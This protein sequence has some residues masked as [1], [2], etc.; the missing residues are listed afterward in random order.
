MINVTKEFKI[1]MS[2]RLENY[3][4]LCNNVHGHTYRLLVTFARNNE[5]VN[6]TDKHKKGM[7]EDFSIIKKLVN[8]LIVDKMDHA[9]VFNTHD[10]DSLDIAQFMSSKINQKLCGL[11]FRTTAENMAEWM[12]KTLNSNLKNSKSDIK[13]TKIVLFET[14]S[15][16]AKYKGE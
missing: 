13:C 7:V 3:D 14:A 4:G 16:F 10:Q 15:S 8:E 6:G 5:D 11:S 2:H 1:D 9:F 12:Y